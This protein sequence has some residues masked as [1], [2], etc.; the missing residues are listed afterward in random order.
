M[1][2]KIFWPHIG[3]KVNLTCVFHS[4]QV[5]SI[6][7]KENCLI[8]GSKGR[9][10]DETHVTRL[11]FFASHEHSC[12]PCIALP[13]LP[14]FR[15]PFLLP[16]FVALFVARFSIA[17]LA[18]VCCLLFATL[19]DLHFVLPFSA[20]FLLPIFCCVFLHELFDVTLVQLLSFAR[21]SPKIAL[22]PS[23]HPKLNPMHLIM[24]PTSKC[25]SNTSFSR[26]HW[27]TA[28]FPLGCHKKIRWPTV[29]QP[30]IQPWKGRDGVS[31]IPDKALQPF[32]FVLGLH[33]PIKFQQSLSFKRCQCF[34]TLRGSNLLFLGLRHRCNPGPDWSA[35]GPYIDL[36]LGYLGVTWRT[37]LDIPNLR[38]FN[39]LLRN[40]LPRVADYA[41]QTL[42]GVHLDPILSPAHRYLCT[43]VIPGTF[44]EI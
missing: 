14:F 29:M 19:P 3:C 12:R 10:E 28:S 33:N 11:W 35:F 31:R 13:N 6:C 2:S 17:Q 43:L 1:I 22:W 8:F 18:F 27:Q 20:A 9:Q 39:L 42:I 21:I 7:Q 15:C 5:L 44:L 26:N 24:C 41:I 23:F 37:F 36:V 32:G 25:C 30:L 16:L 4:N 34:L 40:L 38:G